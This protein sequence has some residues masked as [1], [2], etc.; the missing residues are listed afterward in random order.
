MMEKVRNC[1]MHLAFFCAV[2]VGYALF[3]GGCAAPPVP[4]AIQTGLEE[5]RYYYTQVGMWAD[6]GVTVH[7]TNYRQGDHI[8]PG[9]EVRIHTARGNVIEFT[10]PE[11]DDRRIQMVNQDHHTRVHLVDLF[12]R[13]FGREEVDLSGKSQEVRVAIRQGQVIPGMTRNEVL[14]ARGY[15]PFHETP[16]L[17]EDEWRYWIDRLLTRVVRF[18]EDGKVAEIID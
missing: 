1:G 4:G 3:A 14:K 16:S 8:P 10:I 2:S 5:S 6:R 15:P 17:E 7:G 18:D 11:W 9:T 13:T 12:E